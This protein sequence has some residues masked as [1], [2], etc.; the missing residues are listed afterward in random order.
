MQKKPIQ[1]LVIDDH[2]LII[3]GLKSILEDEDDVMFTGGAN[4]YDEALAFVGQFP[5]DVVLADINM[6][7]KTGIDLTRTLKELHP[8]IK[9]LALT[10]HEDISMIK[11][12]VEAG[13]SGYILK[14]TNMNEVLEA[15]RVVA[16]N[17]KYLGR[18][19]QAVM[20]DSFSS[21]DTVSIHSEN[22]PATLTSREREILGLVA[23]EMS[24][25]EIAN[26]LFISERTVETHRRNIFT[27]TK[28]KSI[29]GLI[30]FALREGLIS[31][32]SVP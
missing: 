12:M 14:R 23:R 3:D 16:A 8:E 31:Q 2:Q 22:A 24:N 13:A 17:G 32:E 4:S 10:M 5:V 20:M 6:P 25:M 1:V 11:K 15:I 7:G 21:N 30:K 27:K 26:K 19:V 28:T 9:V 18:D 29:V